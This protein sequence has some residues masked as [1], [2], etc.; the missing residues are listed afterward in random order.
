V[1][2]LIPLRS[3]HSFQIGLPKLV[4][5]RQDRDA[6][7]LGVGVVQ[8]ITEIE[9]MADQLASSQRAKVTR[10]LE[11][12]RAAGPVTAEACDRTAPLYDEQG[13]QR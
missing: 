1:V 13:L 11:M 2:A 12:V 6:V 3:G 7:E 9:A 4:G 10:I 5:R 8:A